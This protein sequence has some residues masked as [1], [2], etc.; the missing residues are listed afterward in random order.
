MLRAPRE[1]LLGQFITGQSSIKR[2]AS[3][4]MAAMGTA[5]GN[6]ADGELPHQI[7]S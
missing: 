6:D 3:L 5:L 4:I 2:N 1:N 7:L